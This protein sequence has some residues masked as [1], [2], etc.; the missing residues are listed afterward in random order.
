MRPWLAGSEVNEEIVISSPRIYLQ[1]VVCQQR[2]RRES[3]PSEA[4]KQP[5]HLRLQGSTESSPSSSSLAFRGRSLPCSFLPSCSCS[6]LRRQPCRHQTALSSSPTCQYP[7]LPPLSLPSVIGS[8]LSL[9]RPGL[10]WPARS[11]GSSLALS[12]RGPMAIFTPICTMVRVEGMEQIILI[13]M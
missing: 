10:A 1:Y 3:E 9:Y 5:L 4:R 12:A 8:R 6:L 13:N 7:L 2:H 11:M